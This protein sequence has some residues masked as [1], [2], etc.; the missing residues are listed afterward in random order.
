MLTSA[1]D[2]PLGTPPAAVALSVV[3]SCLN[4]AETLATYICKAKR[5]LSTLGVVGEVVVADNG[6][7]AGCQ[8]IARAE[9]AR[10]VDAKR[11]GYGA[12]LMAD[13][14]DSYALEDLGGFLRELRGCA[15][16]L[17]TFLWV[18]FHDRPGSGGQRPP[19]VRSAM[20]I[21]ASG[22]W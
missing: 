2:Q 15:E 21:S 11:R 1:V 17:L 3:L 5:P 4:E 18:G 16:V 20:A 14:D 6:S 7:T 13:A 9:G 19:R 10:L 22:L 8:D 12:A